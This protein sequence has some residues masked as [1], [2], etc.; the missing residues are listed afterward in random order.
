M[1]RS[2]RLV[3]RILGAIFT[4]EGLVGLISPESF[5]ALV[6]WLQ[7]PP[8]WPYSVVLRAFIGI[9]FLGVASPVRSL[10]AVRAVGL[11]TLIGAI[12]GLVNADFGQA[13]HGTIWRV[14]ALVLLVAG[15]VSVWGAGKSRSVA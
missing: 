11:I 7:S 1:L 13:P 2:P 15:I 5:R 10:P 12:V 14:P 9:L 6:V 8:A 3:A 4:A